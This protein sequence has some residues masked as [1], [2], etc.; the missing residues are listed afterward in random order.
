MNFSEDSKPT[1]AL[2]A[3][4]PAPVERVRR[5]KK[6][7]GPRWLR[8]LGKRTIGR[9]RW[10]SLLVVVVGVIV[11]CGVGAMVLAADARNKVEAAYGSLTRVLS[12][13]NGK[14]GTELTLVDFQ[15]LQAGVSELNQALTAARRQIFFLDPLASLNADIA[16]TLTAVD[17]SREV[18]T[19]AEEMLTGLQPTLFFLVAGQD[20]EAVVSQLSSGE[21][22]VELMRIGRGQFASAETRLRAVE[23]RLADMERVGLSSSLILGIEGLTAYADQLEQINT[24]LLNLPDLLTNAL[25]LTDERSYLVLSQ[26]NDELRPSG[27]YISTY[28]WLTIER[29]RVTDYNYSPTTT[30]SPNPPPLSLA[31]ELEIPTWWLSY[32][33]PI[34]AAWDG[35]W[36]ADFAATA[37][38]SAWYYDSG[39]NPRSP[40]DGVIAI[41]I[42]GFEYLLRALGSVTVPGYETAITAD[43]FRQVV[44]DIRAFGQGVEPHKQFIAQM[45]RAIFAEWQASGGDAELSSRVLG[46]LL[47]ALQAKH[48]MLYFTDEG[49]NSAIRLLGWAGEQFPAVDYDYLMVAD[50]NYGNKSNRSI[51]RQIT[52]DVQ[53]FADHSVSSRTTIAYDYPDRIAQYDPAV[54][55]EYHGAL[56]YTNL[57][58][59]FLPASAVLATTNDLDRS[60][61]VVSEPTHTHIVALVTVPYDTQRRFRFEYTTPGMIE[62]FGSNYRYRLLVQKQPG[63]LTDPLSVQVTL[64]PDAVVISVTPPEAARY[65]LEQEILEFRVDLLTDRWIE[66]IYSIG[67]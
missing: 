13:V 56:D 11:V 35:S 58:Q 19:A 54:D 28:G 45:Y 41:D 53:L 52:Y 26:N 37:R 2:E 24:I 16:A 50:T 22:L 40:V 65:R 17:V 21:R 10:T 63:T 5:R 23:A 30:T 14:P 64:P 15:R 51:T 25:G 31:D 27:G 62:A 44:Y 57:M 46:A 12:T 3:D 48:I 9:V 8:A 32:R 6:R 61:Q 39:N 66:I 55:P 34:Y 7:K 49:L 20:D 4:A 59:V 42:V 1:S 33:E 60:P 18:A 29:G 38:M 43:N 67:Q 47:Q 36:Y